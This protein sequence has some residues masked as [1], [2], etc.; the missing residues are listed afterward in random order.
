MTTTTCEPAVRRTRG[1][2]RTRRARALG[3]LLIAAV[4]ASGITTSNAA[5]LARQ[6]NTT[7]GITNALWQN[8]DV[9]WRWEFNRRGYAYTSPGGRYYNVGGSHYTTACGNSTAGWLDNAFYC[10]GDRSIHLDY[11]WGTKLAREFS[12]Y[13][14]YWG[15]YA[16][17]GILAHEW[18]HHVQTLLG[19][20]FA[21]DMG[22]YAADCLSGVFTAWAG[23][24]GLLDA[25]DVGEMRSWLYYR[26]TS[27][28]HGTGPVRMQW[29][30]YGR[31]ARSLEGCLS[32]T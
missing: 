21:G 31:T 15:D 30:D 1:T 9:Y 20:S 3:M 25:S 10:T 17:G 22:E 7:V 16:F 28:G 13:R 18:G 29:F 14:G 5:A 12:I 26:G 6:Q 27:A 23:H 24:V 32:R 11:Q 4:L 8:L 2:S 19:K